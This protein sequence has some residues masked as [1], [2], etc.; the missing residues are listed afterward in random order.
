MGSGIGDELNCDNVEPQYCRRTANDLAVYKGSIGAHVGVFINDPLVFK[1]GSNYSY[2]NPNFYL[3]SYMVEKISGQTLEVYMR[4][5]IF[6][7]IG[8]A[9]TFYDPY[10]GL[11]G[12]SRGY[13]DQY[14]DYYVAS[15]EEDGE[16]K[17]AEYITTGTCSPYMNGGAV[18]GSG[19]FRST[20]EDMHQ[21]Y[22][23]LFHNHGRSSKVL[24]GQSV[25]EIVHRR[26]PVNPS[27]A[28]G[29]GVT[30]TNESE[31]DWPELIT[32]CGGMKCAITCMRMRVF[33]P[34]KSVI[35]TSFTNH[36]QIFFASRA[37]FHAWR[38]T[39]FMF[40]L[41]K[42]IQSEGMGVLDLLN[43]LMTGFLKYY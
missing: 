7:K 22:S 20:I 40:L 19:G 31:S 33:A 12:V 15:S 14:A 3:L 24:S 17:P 28:Q 10:S 30:F 25:S 13:V 21:W 36:V 34:E 38:P 5:Q 4:E 1:P 39:E 27:Y 42:G 43:D 32:Y 11:L 37:D 29:V 23:D 8:L 9:D 2:S 41:H 18:S 6:D 16:S 35:A 26:N